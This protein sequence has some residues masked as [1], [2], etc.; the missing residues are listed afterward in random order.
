MVENR[1]VYSRQDSRFE[2]MVKNQR[3]LCQILLFSLLDPKGL[4]KFCRLNKACRQLLDPKSKY[5]VNFKVLFE[6]WGIQLTPGD[7]N[8]TLISTTRALQVAAKCII[9]N[10]FTRS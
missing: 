4:A 2:S 1:M 8:E 5:C 10:S 9:Y 7:V 6:N 3:G